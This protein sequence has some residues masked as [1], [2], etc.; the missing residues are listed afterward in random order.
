MKLTP[1][2]IAA[3]MGLMAALPAV[4]EPVSSQVEMAA[5][6]SAYTAPCF[7]PRALLRPPPSSSPV[8]A[9]PMATA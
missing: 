2:L 3:Q 8:P 6:P 1:T 9:P 7:A 4:A 5:Q